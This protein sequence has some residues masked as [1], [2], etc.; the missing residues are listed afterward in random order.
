[1]SRTSNPTGTLFTSNTDLDPFLALAAE[2]HIHGHPSPDAFQRLIE[3]S[4]ACLPLLHGL[5][6]SKYCIGAFV[7]C[8]M[9][10]SMLVGFYKSFVFRPITHLRIHMSEALAA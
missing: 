9:L 6:S 7:S 1:M 8:A 4:C 3:T 2:P 10:S 5:L